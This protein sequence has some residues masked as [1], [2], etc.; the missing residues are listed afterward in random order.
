LPK[1]CTGLR[2]VMPEGGSP[3]RGFWYRLKRVGGGYS[4]HF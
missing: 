2:P 4:I 3:M 1:G